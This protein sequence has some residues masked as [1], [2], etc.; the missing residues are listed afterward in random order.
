MDALFS[1]RK[2]AICPNRIPSLH[3][4]LLP[5][6]FLR[7]P[8]FLPFF[9]LLLHSVF[10]SS[11]AN[12][13][14]SD[15]EELLTTQKYNQG[16]FEVFYNDQKV[17]SYADTTNFFTITPSIPPY[18]LHLSPFDLPDANDRIFANLTYV[19]KKGLLVRVSLTTFL[20]STK[21]LILSITELL[22]HERLNGTCTTSINISIL[23]TL[24]LNPK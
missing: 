4:H 7:L 21:R 24:R 22:S 14:V 9:L 19:F 12:F 11:A 1:A 10:L 16:L 2:R 5:L 6:H 18:K 15:F 20:L 3:L 23:T 13:D 8:L 17:T